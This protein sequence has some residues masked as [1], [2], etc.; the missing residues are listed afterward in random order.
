[1]P[2]RENTVPE[3]RAEFI[4]LASQEGSNGSA[5]CRRFGIRR[6]TGYQWLKRYDGGSAES[7]RDRS[8]RPSGSPR[9]TPAA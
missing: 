4:L 9:R 6:K 2:G 8:R 5:L 7:L 3:Q 1:M